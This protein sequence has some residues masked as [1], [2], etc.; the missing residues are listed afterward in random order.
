M[1]TTPANEHNGLET[2]IGIFTMMIELGKPY[3]LYMEKSFLELLCLPTDLSPQD[4][5]AA[6]ES[7]VREDDRQA[8]LNAINSSILGLQSE[9]KYHWLHDRLGWIN[10]SSTG[11]LTD[12]SGGVITIKGFFKGVIPEKKDDGS[13]DS[14]SALLRTMVMDVIMD[15]F[16]VCALANADTN[17]MYFLHNNVF[18]DMA[19]RNLTYDEWREFILGMVFR[20]DADLYRRLSLR[21]TLNAYLEKNNGELQFEVRYLDPKTGRYNRMRQRYIHFS[22][23]LANRYTMLLVFSNIRSDS[24]DDFKE[25]MRRR[26]IDGLALPYRELDLINLKTGVLFTSR[27][28]GGVY[29]E[30]FDESGQFDDAVK[31]YLGDC[32]LTEDEYKAGLD[33]FLTKNLARHFSNGEKLLELECRHKIAGTEVYEWVRIQAFES[34]ADEHRKPYMAIVTVMS[35]NDEKEKELK[36]RRTLEYALR[37]ER[38]YRQAIL[39]SAMV[40][41]SYN[42]TRDILFQEIVEETD[43]RALLPQIGLETPCSYDEY[44]LRKSKY[45]SVEQEA[46]KYRKT[47]CTK[48]LADMFDSKRYSFDVEYEFQIGGRTGVFREAV[49]LTKDLETDEIWGLTTVRNVTDERNENRRIEQALRDAFNQA[50]NA[51]N[52]KTLFMSQMSHDIRTP[53]NSILGMS[54]IAHEHIDDKQRVED[55]LQK[56]DY[57]G[58]HLLEIINN[59]LDLSAIESGKS[60][61]SKEEFQLS[62]FLSETINIITPLVEK[63]H[64]HLSLSIA[65]MHDYVEGDP[66]KLRQVLINVL[67]N[68]IK[69]TPDGGEISFSAVELEP[70]RQDV[71]RYMF[72]VADNG[73]GMPQEFINRI[74]DPFAR[75]DNRRVSKVQG[76]GLG[77]AIALNIAR[78]MN[79]G[80][81]VISE[82]GRGSVFEITV[83]LRRSESHSTNY[84]GEIDLDEPREVRMSDYDFGGRIVLLAEDLEFNAEIAAEFLGEANVRVEFAENG[85]EAVR[86]FRESAPGYYSLI[87]MDIQMPEMDGYEAARAIRALDRPDAKSIPIVAMTANA[88]MDDIKR[89]DEAGMNGHIAKPI[90]IPRLAHELVRHLGD[91]RRS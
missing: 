63:K 5:Y 81:N 38:Q 58:H 65:K 84:I 2:L 52:A 4:T 73:I 16:T 46:D 47:F 33:K 91:C 6:W 45:I 37:S 82:E 10:V 72:T 13:I 68:A 28:R 24:R 8:I 71:C 35:I 70:D 25:S 20:D 62:S 89:A 1:T 14:N 67:G 59:V 30:A 90:E 34:A 42:V 18:P 64:H 7:H 61:L 75:A 88:F 74:F 36:T 11:I 40:V 39:S 83:C 54:A 31:A 48:T 44:I 41:Y 87:F 32:L 56:I 27:S 17:A 43:G 85:T 76:T 22:K 53:L 26:L 60:T 15:S 80:I 9:V 69:Y 19:Q 23:P 12:V 57:A 3:T 66:T 21:Q 50:K 55:C 79:G 51:N 78:M 49:I 29:T 77:M 86:K